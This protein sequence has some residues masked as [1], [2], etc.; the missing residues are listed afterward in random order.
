M[1]ERMRSTLAAFGL[2]SLFLFTGC[3]DNWTF[4]RKTP[5]QPSIIN[6]KSP[7]APELVAYLNEN[8]QKVHSLT[9]LDVDL[10]VQQGLQ[11]VGLSAKLVCEQPRYF[12]MGANSP[13]KGGSEFMLGSND[14]EFWYYIAR[15]NPPYQFFCSYEDLR[16]KR[17]PLPFPF[18]PE[19]VMETLG[20]ANYPVDGQYRVEMKRDAIELIQDTTSLQGEPVQ[21]VVVFNREPRNSQVRAYVLRDMRGKNLCSAQIQDVQ[22][23]GKAVVPYKLVLSWPEQ[24]TKLSMKLNKP[25]LN[26]V[27][28]ESARTLFTRVPMSGIQP[29]NLANLAGD[30]R[31]GAHQNGSVQQ[32][33]GVLR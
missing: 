12:R 18:Q 11:P 8:S 10:D 21:K 22:R 23:I 13:L 1:E 7:T 28:P 9:C 19:W 26:Q 20:M 33:G 14:V 32:A 6:S 25:T 17:I 31:N 29:Y 5:D 2:F 4:L 3:A 16:T 15:A 27:S 30:E 24:N